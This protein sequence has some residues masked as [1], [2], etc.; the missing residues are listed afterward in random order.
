MVSAADAGRK[1]FELLRG[2][3]KGHTNVVTSHGRPVTKLVPP[4]M[5][6]IT[7]LG[8]F[9]DCAAACYCAEDLG[10]YVVGWRDFGQVV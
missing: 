10:F 2:A 3:Q 5:N 7:S 1:F 6:A 9:V 4:E 8:L